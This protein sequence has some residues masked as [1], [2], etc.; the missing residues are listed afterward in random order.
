MTLLAAPEKWL[1]LHSR[2]C[3]SNLPQAPALLQQHQACVIL[4]ALVPQ[5]PP[6]IKSCEHQAPGPMSHHDQAKER[7]RGLLISQVPSSEDTAE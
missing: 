3:A 5:P 4:D 2:L 7:L 1:P 6:C